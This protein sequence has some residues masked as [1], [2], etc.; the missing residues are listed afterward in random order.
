M[1]VL[2]RTGRWVI[3]L[4]LAC[5][6]AAEARAYDDSLL[7][8]MNG[9]PSD[10]AERRSGKEVNAS[11]RIGV[12]NEGIY[13]V[14][15]SNLTNAGVAVSNLVGSMMRLFCRTQ[16]V[17]ILV[18]S[19]NQWTASDYFLFPGAGFDGYYSMTNVYWLGFGLGGKR[20]ATRPAAPVAG[21]TLLTSARTTAWRHVDYYFK[22]TYR[23][24]D[25]T[26]DHW[27]DAIMSLYSLE[28]AFPVLT[29]YAD[30][31]ASAVLQGVLLGKGALDGLNPDHSTR[32]RVNANVA[33]QFDYDGEVTAVVATNIPGTWLSSSNT[34][35]LQQRAHSNDQAYVERLGITYSRF[36]VQ[37][38]NV[39]LFEG[40]AGTNNYRVG[41]F[42]SS[43]NFS[44]MDI[45]DP[46]NGVFLSGAQ[47]TNL[48]AGGHGVLFGE[49]TVSTSRYGVWH[50]AGLRE[51]A[52]IQR[53]AFRSLASV[54][55]GG[56]YVVICPYEF[57]PEVYRL[58]ALRHAQGLSVAVAPLPDIY[59]E[60]SYGIADAAAIKQ[61]IGYAFHHWATAPGYVLL[62]G[63]G[64][65]DPRG[66]E[67][68]T[69][70][71]DIVPVHLGP[72]NGVWTSLDGWYASVHGADAVPDV[73]LGRIP[74]ET[75]GELK[76]VIDKIVAVEGMPSNSWLRTQA[77]MVSDTD[78]P[79]YDFSGAVDALT[80]NR[81]DPAG[82][83]TYVVRATDLS[84]R[85]TIVGYFNTGEFL[86]NYF[87]HGAVD[88]W[89]SKPLLLTND[90]AGLTNSVYPVV[91]M[92]TCANGAFHSTQVRCLA[93]WFLG[94]TV[95]GASAC[96][97]ASGL[98][99]LNAGEPFMD[100]FYSTLLGERRRRIGDALLPA[101]S[102]LATALGVSSTELQ[103]FELFGDPAMIV[104]P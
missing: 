10:F 55:G 30:T 3:L 38:N 8:P 87:G 33:G 83:D 78:E 60:F 15:Y 62:A 44:V 1:S 73:A 45:T 72:G 52:S 29:A 17:A 93:E 74:V 77:L 54:N 32:I 75:V 22:D 50:A 11:I 59:N 19:S 85:P 68:G 99:S 46:M 13:R 67:A 71:R 36:L 49:E 37:S 14:S 102:A 94:G 88:V 95:H 4:G 81:L 100:G 2:M 69:R 64:T 104:N 58:L 53:V 7:P 48:G 24:G 16:E 27:V 70:F 23:W 66:H 51:A 90:V 103:F 80:S 39:L 26:I 84:P 9:Q 35:W 34:L 12:T 40:A 42:A 91:S 20:M 92:M 86:V 63:G 18:S 5:L 21:G 6:P 31:N 96:V 56:R 79:G 57:R 98:A 47:V 76:V 43:N 97:A 28:Q 101:Y 61:F 65:Y 89:S 25:A 82:M 41:G